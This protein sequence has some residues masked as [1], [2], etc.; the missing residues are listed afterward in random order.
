MATKNALFHYYLIYI[1]SN[2]ANNTNFHSKI[3]N[4]A[5][6]LD[7]C[8]QIGMIFTGTIYQTTQLHVIS[9]LT[10]AKWSRALLQNEMQIHY[11]AK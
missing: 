8:G 9:G 7:V 2:C 3:Y 6:N 11:D 1:T 10:S 4:L 5:L